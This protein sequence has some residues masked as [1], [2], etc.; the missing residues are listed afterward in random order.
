MTSFIYE[1]RFWNYDLLAGCGTDSS[2][3]QRGYQRSKCTYSDGFKT[4]HKDV[5]QQK[6]PG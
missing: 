5:T 6:N 2:I 4:Y 3:I 1:L